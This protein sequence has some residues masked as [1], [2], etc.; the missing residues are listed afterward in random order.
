MHRFAYGFDPDIHLMNCS[1][2][3]VEISW[4]NCLWR[5]TALLAFEYVLSFG[6]FPVLFFHSD[7]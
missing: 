6:Y 2:K 3:P 7:F 1:M 4:G 5:H